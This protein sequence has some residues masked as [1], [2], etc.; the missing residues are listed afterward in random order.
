MNCP[1]CGTPNASQNRFCLKCGKP[2]APQNS[3][4][5]PTGGGRM[6]NLT[7]GLPRQAAAP[8]PQ[9]PEP[10]NFPPQQPAYPPQQPIYPPQQNN[11]PPIPQQD[12][13]PMQQNYQNVPMMQQQEYISPSS[14]Q[15]GLSMLNIWGPFAGYGTRRRHVGWLMDG[16][17]SH[18][19][20]LV[21]RIR[22]RMQE[23][24]VP[25]MQ[26]AWQVLTAKGLMVETRPYF[27]IHKGLATL[28]LNV[29]TFG[30]D[31]FISIATYIK[32]PISNFRAMLAGASALL[33]AVGGPMIGS[34]IG[35]SASGLSMFGD[36][37]GAMGGLLA[38]LCCLGPVWSIN[39]LVFPLLLLFSAY[40][41]LTE[42][43]FFALLRVAPNEFNEDDL[44]A[45][46]KAVEQTVRVSLDDIGLN[47]AELHPAAAQGQESRLI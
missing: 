21:Q 31:L 28:G 20:D 46:E 1:H 38:T 2:I 6:S 22:Q 30:K 12:Q 19:S 14:G 27:L 36:N 47:P 32:P 42:R 4:Q 17:A 43:D 29:S 35:A 10:A 41:W 18:L 15:V 24:Q 16:K 37:S 33:F 34:A 13:F 40:K 9:Q 11:Y 3:Q 25:G 5:Q 8:R 45:M 23:R 44:M 7:Q 26:T 39:A